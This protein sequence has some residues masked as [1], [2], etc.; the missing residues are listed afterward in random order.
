MYNK[1]KTIGAKRNWSSRA[2]AMAEF[3]LVLPILLLVVYG[4]LETGRLIFMY[5]AMTN[6]ARE[7]AR[8]GS[9]DCDELGCVP[10]YQNCAAIRDTAKRD[11]FML[12]L[13][14]DEIDI[15]YDEGPGTSAID[16]CDAADGVKETLAV[17]SGDR[18][19]VTI[20]KTFTPI[21]P[22]VPQLETL[23]FTASTARTIPLI[24]QLEGF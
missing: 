19:V 17:A 24:M 5:A 22:M 2:Q 7:A 6:A 4:L 20:T 10:Q 15:T 16:T 11:G 8:F 9:T 1:T 14:D 23:Q 3:A 18:I 12:N 21:V 13:Q